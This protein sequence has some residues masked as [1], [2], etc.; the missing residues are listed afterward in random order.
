[1]T[2]HASQPTPDTVD[3][4]K[5]LLGQSLQLGPRTASLTADTPLLGALPEFDSMTVAYVLTGLEETFGVGIDDDEIS[6]DIFM[7]VGSLAAF[8]DQKL[9]R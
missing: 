6:V 1:M 8:V 2:Q 7:T 9:R 3:V 5:Q 4:V